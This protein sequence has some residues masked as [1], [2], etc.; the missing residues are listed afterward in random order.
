MGPHPA[1]S[2]LVFAT[3]FDPIGF[4]PK[5]H[6]LRFRGVAVGQVAA[7]QGHGATTPVRWKGWKWMKYGLD[8]IYKYHII[9]NEYRL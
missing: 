8:Y 4:S 6:L 2:F 1:T 9:H 7:G 5:P 3:R